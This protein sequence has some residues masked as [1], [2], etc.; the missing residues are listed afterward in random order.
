MNKSTKQK[1]IQKSEHF[2]KHS[3]DI[4]AYCGKQATNFSQPKDFWSGWFVFGVLEHI[5]MDPM[6]DLFEDVCCPKK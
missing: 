6:V 3:G 1:K 5:A 2:S 4:R